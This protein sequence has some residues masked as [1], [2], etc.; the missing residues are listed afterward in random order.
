MVCNVNAKTE[1]RD[2]HQVCE[3]LERTMDPCNATE[4]GKA[5][6]DG[7]E[8]E[9]DDESERSEYSVSNQHLLHILCVVTATDRSEICIR[10]ACLIAII[11]RLAL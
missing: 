9:E 5:D 2:E 8:W 4:G 10:V 6:S 11:D 1:S 7:A 3:Y